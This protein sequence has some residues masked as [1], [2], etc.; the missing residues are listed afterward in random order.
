M[1][2]CQKAQSTLPPISSIHALEALCTLLFCHGGQHWLNRQPA[3]LCVDGLHRLFVALIA[4]LLLQLKRMLLLKLLLLLL[5]LT[6]KETRGKQREG[7][8]SK[9]AGPMY[10]VH[11]PAVSAM[12]CGMCLLRLMLLLL[13]L[14]LTP[15]KPPKGGGGGGCGARGCM[16]SGGCRANMRGQLAGRECTCRLVR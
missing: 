11:F 3:G 16:T 2:G 7:G 1:V 6:A 14:L 13:L 4:A 5:L 12:K 15:L 10:A 9:G 8:R